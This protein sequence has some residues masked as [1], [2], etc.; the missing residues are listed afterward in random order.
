MDRSILELEQ[1]F[2]TRRDPDDARRLFEAYTRAGRSTDA[3]RVARESILARAPSGAVLDALTPPPIEE[4][5]LGVL[6]HRVRSE[7]GYGYRSP[8]LRNVAWAPDER[9]L[10]VVRADDTLYARGDIL[11]WDVAEGPR[12]ILAWD[13]IPIPPELDAFRIEGETGLTHFGDLALDAGGERLAFSVMTE[14]RPKRSPTL[15]LWC[16]LEL[17]TRTL[18]V[19]P[20]VPHAVPRTWWGDRVVGVK[21][22]GLMGTPAEAVTWRIGDPATESFASAMTDLDVGFGTCITRTGKETELRWPGES[23]PYAHWAGELHW[24]RYDPLVALAPAWGGRAVLY[25][26]CDGE[27][28]LN[29]F[30]L[31]DATGRIAEARAPE[32]SGP[33]GTL[34]PCPSGRV[35][36]RLDWNSRWQ[37]LIDFRD[38]TYH[39]LE[40][41]L[42]AQNLCWSPSGRAVAIPC[43]RGVMQ[44]LDGGLDLGA[45]PSMADW[46]RRGRDDFDGLP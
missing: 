36:G 43:E 29:R 45:A 30:A 19:G 39:E 22:D 7:G 37:Q 6:P 15:Y 32:M 42:R 14:P 35:V 10:Y 8:V 28:I 2:K 33:L 16:V 27:E 24:P 25:E 26:A 9:S 23:A 46:K 5:A 34:R 38:G 17:A 4:M 13:E 44:V 11:H 1:R 41:E 3:V 18:H 21:D 40:L 20:A 12:T 31:V